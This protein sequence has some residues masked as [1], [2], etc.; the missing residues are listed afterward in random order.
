MVILIFMEVVINVMKIF[1]K[2]AKIIKI[3]VHNVKFKIKK[4]QTVMY[5]KM[6][7]MIFKEYVKI[8]M[9]NVQNVLMIYC[10]QNVYI[11]IVFYLLANAKKD[12]SLI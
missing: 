12:I 9:S 8:V 2:L 1:V 4:S 3:L 10:V 5:V 7:S 11:M 6:D